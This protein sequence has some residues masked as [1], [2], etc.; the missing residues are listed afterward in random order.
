[1]NPD[2]ITFSVY[3]FEPH[4]FLSVCMHFTIIDQW[5]SYEFMA[6][7]FH[8]MALSFIIGWAFKRFTEFC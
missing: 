2:F 6:V 5:L 7:W 1:M 4:I 3:Q 8:I